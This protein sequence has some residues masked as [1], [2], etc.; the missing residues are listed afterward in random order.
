MAFEHDLGLRTVRKHRDGVTVELALRPA[1]LNSNGVLHGG[2]TACVVD[3][4]AWHAIGHHFAGPRP[5]ITVELKLNYL[6]PI[7][8]KKLRARAYLLRAGKKLCV[9]RVDVFDE[10]RRLAA[11][12]I[13]TYMLL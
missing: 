10:R 11:A 9:S 7:A 12:A 13:V 5:A 3:E 6:L 8:G 2:I 1:L 4:A